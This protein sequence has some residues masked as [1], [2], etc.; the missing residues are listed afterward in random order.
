MFQLWSV[1]DICNLDFNY[2]SSPELFKHKIEVLE[3]HCEEFGRDPAEIEKTI[4]IPLRLES[5][6]KKAAQLRKARGEWTMIGTAPFI[7][8][9]IQQYLDV[10]VEEIMFGAVPSK[11]E[12]FLNNTKYLKTY[13]F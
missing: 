3:R 12:L 7:I 4:H 13:V 5:D 11:P 10:G 1:E 9:R 6:K 8:D 2:P